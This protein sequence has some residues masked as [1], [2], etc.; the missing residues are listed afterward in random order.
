VTNVSLVARGAGITIQRRKS[1]KLLLSQTL[2]HMLQDE[3]WKVQQNLSNRL[4]VNLCNRMHIRVHA[5]AAKWPVH[6]HRY[7]LCFII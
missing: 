3:H 6:A 4:H 1:H 2:L 5:A 7:K